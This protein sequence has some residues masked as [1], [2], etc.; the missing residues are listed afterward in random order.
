MSTR[1]ATAIATA[2]PDPPSP[3]THAT[4]GTLEPH[5]RRLRARDRASLAVLLGR[6]TGIRTGRVDHRHEREA[7]PIGERHRTHG[8]AVAL[9]IGHA[10]VAL[11]P[12]LQV[13]ALLMPDE[14]DRSPV[15]LADVR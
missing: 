11:R 1:S 9:R 5:H 8:L 12:L 10:E 6:D 7:V 3:I 13:A 4:V 2:P 15:E 14:H